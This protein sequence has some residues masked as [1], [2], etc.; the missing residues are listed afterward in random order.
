MKGTYTTHGAPHSDR[1]EFVNDTLQS[2]CIKL[3]IAERPASWHRQSLD[4][5]TMAGRQ[6]AIAGRQRA[7]AGRQRVKETPHIV[8]TI[9]FFFIYKKE[10]NRKSHRK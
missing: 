2:R 8:I 3:K 9:Q 7:M 6:R 10:L 4:R 5:V 1:I